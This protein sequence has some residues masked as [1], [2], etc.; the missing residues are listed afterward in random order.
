MPEDVVR[1]LTRLRD[2]GR[3]LILVTGRE[4]EQLHSVFSDLELFDRVVAENGALLYCPATRAERALAEP[5]RQD[6]VE[7]LREQGVTPLS[8]GHVIVAT[9][10]PYETVVLQTIERFGLELQV[11][12][13]KGAVMVLPPAV[14][15][16]SGLNAALS[17]LGLSPHNVVGVGDAENDHAFLSLCECAVAVDNALP[18]LKDRADL[19]TQKDHGAGV[20]ELVGRIIEDDLRSVELPRHAI[21]LGTQSD[22]QEVKIEPYGRNILVAG[23]SGAGKSTIAMGM[24]ERLAQEG[25]QFCLVDPEGDYDPFAGAVAL[26][27]TQRPP[28]ED[29]VIQL[30]EQPGEQAIISVLGMPIEDRPSFF[31]RLFLRLQEMRS[32]VGRPHWIA[33]D[34]AHHLLPTEWNPA[35]MV[36]PEDS[37]GMILLTVHPEHVSPAMLS[38]VDIIIAVGEAPHET[39]ANFASGIDQQAPP[40]PVERL[41]ASHALVWDRRTQKEPFVIQVALPISERRRHTRKYATGDLAPSKSFYFRGPDGKLN[42]RAQNL[43]MFLQLA[44]GVDDA[45]WLYHLHRGDYS[46]W[47]KEMIGDEELASDAASVEDQGDLSPSE[48]RAAIKAAIEKRYTAPA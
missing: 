8:V 45:T 4:L 9:W 13:N 46:R 40:T 15:K 48:S 43:M 47:F 31:D 36:L 5:P 38:R 7:A 39:L 1:A 28:T 3:R 10:H 19:V 33:L 35:R 11:I 44:A 12:F 37:S 6:F 17:E 21:L 24:L 22:D 16:A 26:G 29:E 20:I 42:L 41:D 2:T 23:T 25:Y 34:E 32:R 30:L 14:S 18:A 27:D